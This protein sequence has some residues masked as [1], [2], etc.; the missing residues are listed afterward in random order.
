MRLSATNF[1]KN[2]FQSIMYVY[3]YA[4]KKNT[5]VQSILQ[6]LANALD[7]DKDEARAL[8]RLVEF[9]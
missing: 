8:T 7:A 3:K 4:V 2:I 5:E 6:T 9:Y 1:W